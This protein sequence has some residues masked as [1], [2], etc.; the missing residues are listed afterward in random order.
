[1]QHHKPHVHI[2]YG[3]YEASVGI[4]GELLAGDL[5]AKQ[6]KLVQAWTVIHEEEL[7]KAWNL[8]VRNMAFEKIEPLKQEA[9]NMYIKDGI[10]YADNYHAQLKINVIRPLADYQLW[11]RFNTGETRVF[12][13]KPLLTAAVFAPLKDPEVFAGVYLDH[14]IPVWEDGAIDIAPE[15]I[16][17]DG[18]E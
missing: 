5:P 15:K 14:G 12:D 16:Y 1:M 17:S 3:E 6:L 10:A 7:Y 2:S 11:A 18:V 8:A 13:F 4:D 9:D